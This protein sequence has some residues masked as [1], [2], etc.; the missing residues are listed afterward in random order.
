MLVI[1]FVVLFYVNKIIIMKYV[2][3]IL[4]NKCPLFTINSLSVMDGH[5]R[6]LKN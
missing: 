5:D 1:I 2:N 3:K 4:F 6:P